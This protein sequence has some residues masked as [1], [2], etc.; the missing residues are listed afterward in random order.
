MDGHFSSDEYKR[1]YPDIAANSLKPEYGAHPLWHYID[2][3]LDE[4]RLCPV[5]SSDGKLYAGIFN[6]DGYLSLNPDVRASPLYQGAG[7]GIRHF[8][9]YGAKENRMIRVNLP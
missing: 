6:D 1:L 2:Y 9:E 8:K 4:G 3:G 7:G 5:T